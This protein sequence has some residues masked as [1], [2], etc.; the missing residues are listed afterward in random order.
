MSDQT[1]ISTD[2]M[3][4]DLRKSNHIM[5]PVEFNRV[6][7]RLAQLKEK[8]VKLVAFTKKYMMDHT[9]ECIFINYST[10]TERECDCGFVE[11][12]AKLEQ[13]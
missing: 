9:P 7:D 12:L 10:D 2:E 3:I 11:A 6:A 13:E 4:H 5:R 1:P 8:N